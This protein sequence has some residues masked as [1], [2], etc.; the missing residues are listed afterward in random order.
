MH[1]KLEQL[2]ADTAVLKEVQGML[3]RS[4]RCQ[5]ADLPHIYAHY[6]SD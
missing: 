2:K 4:G 6:E 1:V 3:L 5:P